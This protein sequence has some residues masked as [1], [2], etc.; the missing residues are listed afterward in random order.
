MKN[1]FFSCNLQPIQNRIKKAPLSEPTPFL[2]ALSIIWPVLLY[3]IFSQA[4][5]IIY[6]Y[7]RQWILMEDTG[8]PVIA[9]YIQAHSVMV[10][11]SVKAFS[12]I[13]GVLAVWHYFVRETPVITLPKG[14]KKDVFIL[15]GLGG[16]VAVALNFLFA[17]IGFTGS[18]ATYE[19]VAE[20]QF[21]LPVWAGIILYGIVSPIAEEVVFRG[22]VYNRL[23]RQYSLRMAVLASSL[24]FGLYHGNVVQALYGF[25]LGMMIAVLYEKYGSFIVP[26]VLHSAANIF[27]YVASGLIK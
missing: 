1:H 13:A 5:L 18:S 20:K 3:N 11:G 9:D 22:I 7:F 27:V 2:K 12:M 10:S 14:C 17:L 25:V 19:Q 4:V 21:A 23:H 24:I 15:F 8:I 16:S 6:A 26:V